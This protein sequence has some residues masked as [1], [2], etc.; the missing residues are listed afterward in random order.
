MKATVDSDILKNGI[1]ATQRLSP[2]ISGNIS[3]KSEGGKFYILSNSET[4]NCCVQVPGKVSGDCLFAVPVKSLQS[5]I[6]GHSDIELSYSNTIFY[7]KS[8][9]YSVELNTVD[10]LQ[11]DETVEKETVDWKLS[12]EQME[13]LRSALSIVYLKPTANLTPYMPASIRLTPKQAVIACYDEQHMAF[14]SNKEVNGELDLT[15]PI[16]T[17]TAIAETFGKLPCKIS[18]GK[19]QVRVKNKFLSANIA[20]PGDE[21]GSGL[22]ADE[23]FARAKEAMQV[24]GKELRLSKTA[25]SQFMRNA[26][27]VSTKERSELVVAVDDKLKMEVTTSSGKASITLKSESK[28]KVKFKVDYEFFNEALAK[29]ADEMELKVVGD[30]FIAFKAAKCNVL[31]ALNQE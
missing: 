25:I 6:E 28:K 7:I 12:A 23:V 11:I 1:Q 14:L 21:V 19:S 10:A 15:L 29:C 4:S 20:L 31:V 9:K 8:K 3:V 2:T 26:T 30:A 16:D 24:S 17:L 18:V 13:W 5:A 27:A 22:T